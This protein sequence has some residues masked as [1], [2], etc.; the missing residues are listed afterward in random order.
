MLQVPPLSWGILS[1]SLCS[2]NFLAFCLALVG[3]QAYT[4]DHNSIEETCAAASPVMV[5]PR[6]TSSSL[7]PNMCHYLSMSLFPLLQPVLCKQHSGRA[8]LQL[9]LSISHWAEMTHC[10]PVPV[11][12][13]RSVQGA[14]SGLVC[15]AFPICV[16]LTKSLEVNSRLSID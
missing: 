5:S 3:L 2:A 11:L 7:S 10:L 13:F 4:Q 15:R 6:H 16:C 14:F 1:F 9:T 8:K 12:L